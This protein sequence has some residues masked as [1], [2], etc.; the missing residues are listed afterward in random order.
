M[1]LIE[2]GRQRSVC[3]TLDGDSL[4]DS[5]VEQY[6][7]GRISAREAREEPVKSRV[8]RASATLATFKLS[9]E[10]FSGMDLTK[11]TDMHTEFLQSKWKY[12]FFFSQIL[13][14]LRRD[15]DGFDAGFVSTT[16]TVVALKN[17]RTTLPCERALLRLDSSEL[18]RK[19][20]AHQIVAH[21][22][23]KS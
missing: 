9:K 22:L 3:H 5:H 21:I 11:V 15:V 12:G 20:R 14:L 23:R 19:I 17:S 13:T 1:E 6:L 4:R 2:Y 18:V 8:D 10:L 7:E 16:L